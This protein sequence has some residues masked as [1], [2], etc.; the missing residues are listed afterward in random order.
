[1]A[2]ASIKLYVKNISRLKSKNKINNV[3]DINVY[4]GKYYLITI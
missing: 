3:Q 2:Y 4:G 1:M